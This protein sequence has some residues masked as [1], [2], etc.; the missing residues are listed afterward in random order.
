MFHKDGKIPDK[1]K[2]DPS[3]TYDPDIFKD[4]D[5]CAGFITIL[6]WRL[7]IMNMIPLLPIRE[8]LVSRGDNPIK[9]LSDLE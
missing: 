9:Q 8:I 2:T 5:L 6:P 7:Q 3:Y 1:V 4:A